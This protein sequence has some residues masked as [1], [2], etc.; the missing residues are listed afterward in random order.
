MVFTSLCY[1]LY[2]GTSCSL[3]NEMTVNILLCHVCIISLQMLTDITSGKDKRPG[4][5]TPMK[6]THLFFLLELL[7]SSLKQIKPL[8]EK[9]ILHLIIMMDQHPEIFSQQLVLIIFWNP[10]PK[11]LGKEK[12]SMRANFLSRKLSQCALRQIFKRLIFY[13]V[14]CN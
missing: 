14:K 10:R 4:K 5:N 9:V 1:S 6:S 7:V 3:R 11:Y 8:K 12:K 13:V 2:S